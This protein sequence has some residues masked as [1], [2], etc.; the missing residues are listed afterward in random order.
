MVV[1]CADILEEIP[2]RKLHRRVRQV[3][4]GDVV[5]RG[6]LRAREDVDAGDSGRLD[7]DG[8]VGLFAPE[9]GGHGLGRVY[10]PG[11]DR[12]PEP[13]GQAGLRVVVDEE[14]LRPLA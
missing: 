2:E 9:D 10:L 13:L 5:A 14:D 11:G 7:D 4:V 3:W 12:T 1:V 8:G 6:P